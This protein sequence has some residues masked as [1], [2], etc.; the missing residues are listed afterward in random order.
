[1]A[2]AGEQAW[3]PTDRLRA[4]VPGDPLEGGVDILDPSVAVGDDDRVGSLLDGRDEPGSFLLCCDLLGDV[5]GG[6]DVPDRS[7]AR[8]ADDLGLFV[9]NPHSAVGPDDPVLGRSSHAGLEVLQARCGRASII[10]MD[11]REVRLQGSR[12]SA[13]LD[14]EHPV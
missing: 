3:I 9:E 7:T 6:A 10:G 13:G 12:E 11:E 8:I 2:P 1:M 14:P 4:A 5:L